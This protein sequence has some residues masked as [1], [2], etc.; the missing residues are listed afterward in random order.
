M[1]RK[2]LTAK[3]IGKSK[4]DKACPNGRYCGVCRGSRY[5]GKCSQKKGKGERR[6]YYY[7]LKILIANDLIFFKHE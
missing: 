2:N 7:D 5:N 4:R 3:K 1:R 6:Q